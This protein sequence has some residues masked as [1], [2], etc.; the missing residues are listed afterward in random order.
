MAG[1]AIVDTKKACL[2]DFKY[3]TSLDL[4]GVLQGLLHTVTDFRRRKQAH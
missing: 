1:N 4:G 3:L 2:G